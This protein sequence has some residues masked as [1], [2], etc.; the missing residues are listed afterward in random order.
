M[1]GAVTSSLV[2]STP[3]IVV[4]VLFLAGDIVLC[5]W[6]RHFILT[7]PLSTQVYKWILGNWNVLLGITLQWSSIPCGS[8]RKYSQSLHATETGISA[9]LMGHLALMQTRHLLTLERLSLTLR[10]VTSNGKRQTA[11]MKLLP[12]S[13][14]L[15]TV[16]WKYLY[17]W[18]LVGDIFLFV[19]HLRRI[20]RKEHKFAVCR[21]T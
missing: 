11:K 9:G 16:E 10:G 8:E 19:C 21:L 4:R 5:S 12:L 3:Y 7:V 15:W 14:A 13:L 20:R 17:L 1:T 6:A 2:R 18:R